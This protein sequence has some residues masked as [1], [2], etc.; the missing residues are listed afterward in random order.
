MNEHV[1]VK[2]KAYLNN[3]AARLEGMPEQDR[4]ELLRQIEA[5]I[6]DALEAKAGDKEAEVMDLETVLSEMDPP[7]SYGQSQNRSIYGLSQSKWALLISMG[8]LVLAGLLVVLSGGRMAVWIPFFLFL[9]T[10]IAAFVLG[11][12]SWRDTFGKAAVLTSAALS[13]FAFLLCS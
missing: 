1:R 10:Q 6:H 9:G 12:L 3:V 11:I 5:H 13:V 8:G 4:Q 7:E 2:V